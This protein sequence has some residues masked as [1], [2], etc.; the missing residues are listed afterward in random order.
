MPSPLLDIGSGCVEPM[1]DTNR[2]KRLEGWF[3]LRVYC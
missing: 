2:H 1:P 3:T